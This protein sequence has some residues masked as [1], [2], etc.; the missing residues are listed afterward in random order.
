MNYIE[1]I[2]EGLNEKQLDAVKSTEGYVRVTAGAGSGKTKTLTHRYAYLVECMGINPSKILCLT[3]TNKAAQEIR[4]RISNLVSCGNTNDFVTTYHGFG[5]KFL[6][7]EIYKLNYS[8]SFTILDEED[9][10]IL[11]KEIYEELDLNTSV[12]TYKQA[13][14]QIGTFKKQLPLGEYIKYMLPNISEDTRNDLEKIDDVVSLYIKKQLKLMALDFNDLIYFTLYI[15]QHYPEVAKHWQNELYYIMVDEMQDNN[16]ANWLLTDILS[17][18][19]KNIFA[20]GD[21][22]QAIYE[23]RGAIPNL[24][25]DFHKEHRP[26]KDVIMDENYRSTPNILNVANSVIDKNNNRIKKNLFTRKSSGTTVVHYHGKDETD[27]CTWI[28]EQIKKLLKNGAKLSDISILY[29]ASYLSRGIE[30]ALMRNDLKY[31]IYGGIR[32]F[33]RK[34]IKDTLSYLR[35]IAQED[36]LSFLRVLNT[37]SRKIGKVFRK[38]LEEFAK[39]ERTSLYETLKRHINNNDKEFNK[40]SALQFINLIEESKEYAKTSS[41]SDLLEYIMTKSGLKD[42]I[43]TDG[44]EER[45]ENLNE[46]MQSISLYEQTHAEENISL[47]TYLQDIALY[48]NLDYKEDRDTIK[49][50]TIHQAK[51]LE[52]PF[53]FVIGLNEGIFPNIKTLRERRK[54]GLEEERRLAYVAFTRAEKALFLTESEGYNLATRTDKYP[55]RFL[56][57]IEQGLC[58]IEGSLNESLL[59]ETKYLIAKENGNEAISSTVKFEVGDIVSHYILGEGEVIELNDNMQSYI[60]KFNVGER[61][62]MYGYSGLMLSTDSEKRLKF[63]KAGNIKTDKLLIDNKTQILHKFKIGDYCKPIN[64]NSKESNITITSFRKTSIGIMVD[65]YADDGSQQSAIDSFFILRYT[66][67]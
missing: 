38:N 63:E 54:N 28:C 57:E 33:E 23:W 43:R 27:E 51:G 61:P 4:K 39:K 65:F 10:K 50:M 9:V 67:K 66:H 12:L 48:T 41:I 32:F 13:L 11:L 49:L 58:A 62:I 52:F 36:D 46:L 55:S 16:A 45:I 37:P 22:D 24:F 7:Q 5:V 30:Q 56:L 60:I 1:R 2:L 20:V 26:C 40:E 64:N 8:K 21:P 18:K 19:H 53:V 14:K 17:S 35:L 34:E 29:R 3:F 59:E 15:L 6:R 31:T 25:I 42:D 44:N 47:V